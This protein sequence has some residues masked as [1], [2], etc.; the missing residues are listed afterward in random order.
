MF[1][2]KKQLLTWLSVWLRAF[3]RLLTSWL[4][5]WWVCW[6]SFWLVRFCWRDSLACWRSLWSCWIWFWRP[7]PRDFNWCW[8]CKKV[9]V[10]K[11]ISSRKNDQY[12]KSSSNH[13]TIQKQKAGLHSDLLAVSFCLLKLFLALGQLVLTLLELSLGL[14][15]LRLHLQ[16]QR[17]ETK[18]K[19]F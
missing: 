11:T 15:Q 2:K 6:S 1:N 19:H 7:W 17:C 5:L 4:W 18:A 13:T 12:I 3:L 9:L 10:W 14:G 16:R 8:T